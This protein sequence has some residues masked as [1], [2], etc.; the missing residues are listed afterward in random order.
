VLLWDCRHPRQHDL[1]SAGP[2]NPRARPGRPA[3]PPGTG[4]A[5][6]RGR[7]GRAAETRGTVA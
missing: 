7:P 3:R 6:G 5:P 1:P 4:P 2:V